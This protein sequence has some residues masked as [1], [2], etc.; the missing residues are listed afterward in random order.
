MNEKRNAESFLTNC[1]SLCLRQLTENTSVTVL[2]IFL[3]TQA[4]TSQKNNETTA[5]ASKLA[6]DSQDTSHLFQ[7]K[8]HVFQGGV[9]LTQKQAL[10]FNIQIDLELFFSFFDFYGDVEVSLSLLTSPSVF[11]FSVSGHQRAITPSAH[12]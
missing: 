10:L 1:Y 5:P 4:L 7:Y 8:R 11:Y 3:S 6:S 12:K 9:K 2:A